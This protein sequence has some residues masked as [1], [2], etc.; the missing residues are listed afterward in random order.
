L[1]TS[2]GGHGVVMAV[3]VVMADVVVDMVVV[4]MAD[5]V[6]EMVAVV[7]VEVPWWSR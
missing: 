2:A 5:V 4:V 3:I 1:V 7:V 6:A